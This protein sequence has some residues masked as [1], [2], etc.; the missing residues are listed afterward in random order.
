M[1]CQ[2]PFKLY[3]PP[4]THYACVFYTCGSKT[5][6][7]RIQYNNF[8]CIAH[9]SRKKNDQIGYLAKIFAI[10]SMKVRSWQ[11]LMIL[12]LHDLGKI[13]RFTHLHWATLGNNQNIFHNIW[14]SLE[15]LWHGWEVLRFFSKIR[16]I[17]IQ[18]SHMSLSKGRRYIIQWCGW[19]ETK[20]NK[21]SV[22][23]TTQ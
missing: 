15:C 12:C 11:D 3:L 20:W 6:I 8:T 19:S 23:G 1:F 18:K 14:K 9:K 10:L 5:L 7:T 4:H 13:W 17:W 21:V 16:V 2:Y 22:K